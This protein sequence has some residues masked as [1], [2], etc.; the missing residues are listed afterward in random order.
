MYGGYTFSLSSLSS[1][2]LEAD[3]TPPRPKILQ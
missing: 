1:N 2:R 3:P